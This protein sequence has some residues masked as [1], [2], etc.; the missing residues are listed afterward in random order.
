M[1]NSAV[2][3]FG[4]ISLLTLLLS[5]VS[6]TNAFAIAHKV[7]A[8]G[9][10]YVSKGSG[11]AEVFSAP[12]KISSELA[13]QPLWLTFYD[14]YGGRP[15][16]NWVRV[17]L[18]APG[19]SGELGD[20]LADERTFVQKRALTVNVSGRI[21]DSGRELYIEAKGEKGAIFSWVLT[22]AKSSLSVLN[23]T[24]IT[25]GKEFLLHG[26]GFSSNLNENVVMVD[27]KRASV[28]GATPQTLRVNAPSKLKKK[29]SLSVSVNGKSSNELVV[30]IA[31]QPP[32]LISISPY[33]GPVGGLLNIRGANF[34]RV[35][36][37]NVVR[38]GALICPVVKVMDTGTLI[39]RIPNWGAAGGFPQT[40][41]LTISVNGVPSRNNLTF[42]CTSH[43][44]GGDPS[45]A[46]YHYD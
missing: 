7:V 46:I 22:T 6:I 39:C 1:G 28:I 45:A 41:P 9:G 33:G 19:Q 8:E 13:G 11:K 14:G 10:P 16:Y 17:F 30:A 4:V 42:W 32:T 5:G 20:L 34:S 3:R 36:D 2:T 35:A 26:T 12:L 43:Y 18:K 40:L 25:P 44:Y 29:V 24:K 23:V 21:P 37:E 31:N 27:G 38:I 15:G